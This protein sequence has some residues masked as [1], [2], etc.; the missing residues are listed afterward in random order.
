MPNRRELEVIDYTSLSDIKTF[1]VDIHHRNMHMHR[2]FELFEV[3]EGRMEINCQNATH[4]VDQGGLVLLNP[5]QPHEMHSVLRTPVRIMPLQVS[6]SFFARHFPQL[7]NVEF[8]LVVVHEALQEDLKEVKARYLRACEAYLMREPYFELTCSAQINLIMRLL[9]RRLPWHYLTEKEKAAKKGLNSRVSRII[10]YIEDH[11]TQKLLLKDICEKEQLS[12]AYLSRYFSE[13]FNM[14]FQEYL[15]LLRF[16]RAKVLAE[17]TDMKL[18]DI[19]LSSGFSDIRYLNRAFEQHLNC[20][21]HSYRQ[22]LKHQPVRPSAESKGAVQRF[23]SEEETRDFF[24][25]SGRPSR[26]FD[27]MAN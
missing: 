18:T 7:S 26:Q 16:H 8:D 21:V 14:S 13:H 17:R 25:H 19:A 1:L 3:L 23:L 20:S 24:V 15:T 22:Q 2:E 6:P 27:R 4:Q 5:R 11:Y 9:L 12:L 10:A